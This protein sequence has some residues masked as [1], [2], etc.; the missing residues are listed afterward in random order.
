MHWIKKIE[1]KLA[2]LDNP[3]FFYRK[4]F[5]NFVAL[6]GEIT[7]KNCSASWDLQLSD[8]GV[9]WN[10][11]LKIQKKSIPIF[12][13]LYETVFFDHNTEYPLRSNVII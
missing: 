11:F 13:R 1:N 12:S 2:A 5:L 7:I 3:L 9:T 10:P 6:L 4:Y 8:D